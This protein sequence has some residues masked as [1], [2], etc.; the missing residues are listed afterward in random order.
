VE[1]SA[2][3]SAAL[4]IDPSRVR[5]V[6]ISSWASSELLS[7]LNVVLRRAA[8]CLAPSPPTGHGA[9][10]GAC[11]KGGAGVSL[12]SALESAAVRDFLGRSSPCLPFLFDGEVWE[13]MMLSTNV[14][15]TISDVLDFLILREVWP[16]VMLV[17]KSCIFLTDLLNLRLREVLREGSSIEL[18]T[19]TLDVLIDEILETPLSWDKK[20]GVRP[21]VVCG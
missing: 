2:P 20:L 7:K 6:K 8:D 15:C 18:F 9:D 4:E 17:P 14:G 5:C 3:L 16:F 10:R 1:R 12:R 21:K 13:A 19:G 11:P